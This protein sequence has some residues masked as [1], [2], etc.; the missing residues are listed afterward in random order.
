[1][2]LIRFSVAVFLCFL[3]YVDAACDPEDD[4]RAKVC[5][6]RDLC[7]TMNNE[8]TPVEPTYTYYYNKNVTIECHYNGRLSFFVDDFSLSWKKGK[9]VLSTVACRNLQ[10]FIQLSPDTNNTVYTCMK[11]DTSS[12]EISSTAKITFIYERPKPKKGEYNA[13]I[14]VTVNDGTPVGEVASSSSA[15]KI[16][17]AEGALYYYFDHEIVNVTCSMVSSAENTKTFLL[18]M[19]Y[20]DDTKK[21]LLDEKCFDGSNNRDMQVSITQELTAFMTGICY[22][23]SLLIGENAKDKTCVTVQKRNIFSLKFKLAKLKMHIGNIIGQEEDTKNGREVVHTYNEENVNL[24]ARCSHDDEVHTYRKISPVPILWKTEDLD[25][26]YKDNT[27]KYYHTYNDTIVIPLS[28][29]QSNSYIDCVENL[30]NQVSFNT[31]NPP[32]SIRLR[33]IYA[34]LR[35]YINNNAGEEDGKE[36]I[37][38]KEVIHKYKQENAIVIARC[39]HAE[40]FYRSRPNNNMSYTPILWKTEKLDGIFESLDQNSLKITLFAGRNE[41]YIDCEDNMFVTSKQNSKIRLRFIYENDVEVNECDLEDAER[42]KICDQKRL[43]ITINDKVVKSY[44]YSKTMDVTVECHYS[45]TVS[46]PLKDDFSIHWKKGEQVISNEEKCRNLKKVIQLSPDTNNTVYTCEKYSKSQPP[47]DN[48]TQTITFLYFPDVVSNP[49]NA[50]EQ[51]SDENLTLNE[52][53]KIFFESNWIV[54]V[55]GLI[56]FIV[57]VVVIV[58]TCVVLKS[59]NSPKEDKTRLNPKGSTESLDDIP[60]IQNKMRSE[61]KL[62]DLYTEL[63]DDTSTEVYCDPYTAMYTQPIPK[64]ARKPKIIPKPL[65]RKTENYSNTSGLEYDE[66]SMYNN[67]AN[68]TRRIYNNGPGKTGP[69]YYNIDKSTKNIGAT[70]NN[71]DKSAKNIGATYNNIDKSAKNTGATYNNIAQV[72]KNTKRVHIYDNTAASYTNTGNEKYSSD[73]YSEPE[74]YEIPS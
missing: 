43:C 27:I 68:N 60:K 19:L 5:G 28:A 26:T 25:S 66:P 35:I 2:A 23:C 36:T 34:K 56:V 54:L 10:R 14:T 3:S 52:R 6:K 15:V 64:S 74:L 33:F 17:N 57:V 71:I 12:R 63:N 72:L 67:V 53:M 9:D 1:M 8:M 49:M 61:P 21:K 22:K 59:K 29:D 38:D 30:G 13:S 31:T 7:I 39:S 18:K 42:A 24:T 62:N 65:P 11:D 40:E 47:I 46:K 4:T 58:A 55:T 48:V 16:T 51:T 37:Y 50:E 41:S 44:N 45:E 32:N 70:Y 73:V 20:S 69:N